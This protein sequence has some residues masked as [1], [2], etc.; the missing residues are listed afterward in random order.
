ML[1]SHKIP[2][3]CAIFWVKFISISHIYEND[4][5]L[6]TVTLHVCHI[7]VLHIRICH[8]CLCLERIS[9]F[10]VRI[11]HPNSN[12]TPH[13]TQMSQIFHWLNHTNTC[14]CA[15]FLVKFISICHIYESHKSM[16]TVKPRCIYGL[17]KSK[18]AW[19]ENGREKII[20]WGKCL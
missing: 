12:H 3:F 1:G 11:I 5:P 6:L 17:T 9:M 16:L 2:V 20:H 4:K 13:R 8:I 18:I 15:I 14:F 10:F 7:H 19:G